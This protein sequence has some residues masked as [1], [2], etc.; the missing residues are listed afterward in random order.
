[1][2]K[3]NQSYVTTDLLAELDGILEDEAMFDDFSGELEKTAPVQIPIKP[4]E[5]TETERETY[6]KERRKHSDRALPDSVDIDTP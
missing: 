5:C 4:S 6:L 1:M 2:T 3:K